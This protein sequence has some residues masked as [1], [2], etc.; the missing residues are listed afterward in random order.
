M[1]PLSGQAT[2]R[3]P[4][5]P[6][7]QSLPQG[8]QTQHIHCTIATNTYTLVHVLTSYRACVPACLLAHIPPF[9]KQLCFHRPPGLPCN[10]MTGCTAL[11]RPGAPRYLRTCMRL[12]T[13]AAN[14]ASA[15]SATRLLLSASEDRPSGWMKTRDTDGNSTGLP[16]CWGDNA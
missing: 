15:A 10:A 3:N 7:H 8:L 14:S 12:R 2:N 16:G 4:T 9:P 6:Y 1:T 11:R 5:C 13:V